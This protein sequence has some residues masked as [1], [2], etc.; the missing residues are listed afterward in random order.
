MTSTRSGG[1][2]A[3]HHPDVARALGVLRTRLPGGVARPRRAVA[4]ADDAAP[5]SIVVACSGGADSV[6]L[7]GLLAL[8]RHSE[9]LSLAVA[10]VD[11][12]LRPE[13]ATEADLVTCLAAK[14][15]MPMHAR[16][17]ALAPGPG[18]PARARHAR[19]AALIEVATVVGARWVALGHTQTDQAET[20]LLHL[21]RGAGSRGN[22]GMRTIT[23]WPTLPGTD[24]TSDGAWLRP[25]LDLPRSQTRALVERLG[26]PFA[27]DPTN[28]SRTA[29]RTLIR[30]EVLPRL[31]TINPA[32]ERAIATSAEHAQRAEDALSQWAAAEFGRR[33]RRSADRSVSPPRYDIA[34]IAVLPAEVRWRLIR[35]ACTEH[36]LAADAVSAAVVGQV[37]RAWCRPGPARSWDLHPRAR[38]HLAKGEFWVTGP[39]SRPGGN[40]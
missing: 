18:L 26:L 16:R 38:L 9:S 17:V 39:T 28:D 24:P 4:G 7:L 13:S 29:P 14:L 30:H 22:S 19:Q 33:R 8:L 25:M 40:H 36:G 10:H 35:L 12:G 5:R 23:P 15:D 1:G 6:T 27:D 32:V 21:T 37:D 11:H 34:D 31:A 2:Q 3:R 20:V